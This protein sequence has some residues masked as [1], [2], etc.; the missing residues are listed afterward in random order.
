MNDSTDS[1]VLTDELRGFVFAVARRIVRDDE[2]AADV[3]QDALLLAHRHRD[4]F[5]GESSYRTWLYRIATTTALGHLRRRRRLR[6]SLV[7]GDEP[8]GAAAPDPAPSP[9]DQAATH[10]VAE[11]VRRAL[12]G[13]DHKYRDVLLA[14]ADDASESEVAVRLGVSLAN[15]KIRTHRARRQLRDALAA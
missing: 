7:P 3:T 2:D 9:E 12:D 1:P 14:R 6:E 10:E 11:Q 5:R 4:S 8:V 13:L 15:V